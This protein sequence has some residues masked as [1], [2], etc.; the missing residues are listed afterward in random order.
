MSMNDNFL[1]IIKGLGNHPLSLTFR[2]KLAEGV[3][4]SPGDTVRLNG[5][6]E[7]IL[8]SGTTDGMAMWLW[9]GDSDFDVANDGGDPATDADAWQP[10]G[11][12]GDITA[13]V[14]NGACEL[15][16]TEFVDAE[17]APNALL[18]ANTSG[19]SAG[20]LAAATK[21]THNVCGMVSRGKIMH[22]GKEVLAFWPLCQLIHAIA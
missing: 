4:A 2:A 5:D 17:Y 7:Y 13:F 8:G 3:V 20:K 12:E 6:G 14:A 1:D 9:Q 21:G 22:Q 10:V 15:V 11:P 18:W 19:G 16:T